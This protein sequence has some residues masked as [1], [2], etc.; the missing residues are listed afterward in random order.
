MKVQGNTKPLFNFTVINYDGV[1]DLIFRENIEDISPTD[2]PDT[3]YQWDEYHLKR[4][5][6]VS[7]Y[8]EI[9]ANYNPWFNAAKLEDEHRTPI[10]VYQLRADTDYLEVTQSAM[11]GISVMSLASDPAVLELARK[12]YPLRWS[13]ERLRALVG[14][15][16][17]TPEDFEAVTGVAY[18]TEVAG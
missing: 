17:I 5:W 18:S 4:P 1:A 12:Y 3:L 16:K 15:Q 14:M 2:A 10:D 8:D 13:E 11:M 6:T 9:M 7:I